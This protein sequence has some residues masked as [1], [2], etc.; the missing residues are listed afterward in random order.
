MRTTTV[1]D[2][3]AITRDRRSLGEIVVLA[4]PMWIHTERA[5][6]AWVAPQGAK[7]MQINHHDLSARV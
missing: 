5:R 2:D 3:F 4:K 6:N 1:E 7:A